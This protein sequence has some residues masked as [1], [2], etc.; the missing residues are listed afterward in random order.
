MINF[1]NNIYIYIYDIIIIH[2]GGLKNIKYSIK[3]NSK[4]SGQLCKSPH[5][6]T[7]W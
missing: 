5:S 7:V 2:I 4:Y 3:Y 6:D 1:L